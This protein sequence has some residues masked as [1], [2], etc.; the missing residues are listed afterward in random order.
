[1]QD[2]KDAPIKATQATRLVPSGTNGIALVEVLRPEDRF[3]L[4]WDRYLRI[5]AV[6]EEVKRI[7]RAE[8]PKDKKI[9]DVGGFDGALALF[10]VDEPDFEVEVIDPCTTGASGNEIGKGA[11]SYPIVVAIDALEHVQPERR[12]AFLAEVSRVARD[13]C[14]LNFP[15]HGT[16]EAQRLVL[17][18]TGDQFIREHVE[19]VLPN[20]EQ[21]VA[22]MEG[23][24]FSCEVIH[25]G[26]S[27]VWVS[28]FVLR[29]V[30]PEAAK[31]TARFQVE[32]LHRQVGSPSEPL[33]DM[34][35]CKR[36]H[37]HENIL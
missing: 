26:D 2:K 31:A 22:E 14:I 30:A 9:L 4:A 5:N 24:G 12:S 8:K 1:M 35:V 19:Y 25:H 21:V 16:M 37:E 10:F 17:S 3:D 33:Y 34:I 36:V 13:H 23:H 29:H 27:M 7:V 20:H 18:L 15:S 11:R 28:Q 32:R 6:A